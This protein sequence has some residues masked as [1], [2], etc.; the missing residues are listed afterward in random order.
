M[1]IDLNALKQELLDD[2]LNLGYDQ[3]VS[4]RN[5]LGSHALIN[6]VGEGSDFQ[7]SRGRISKDHFIEITTSMVFNL[8][9]ALKNGNQDAQF[10]LDVFD[11]LVANSDTINVD[12]PALNSILNEMIT[13]G[14]LTSQDLDSIKTR[15]GS[16][17]EKLF[18]IA[19]TVDQVSNSLNEVEN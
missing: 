11:R 16:R 6:S 18:G 17:S 10:W 3:F 9:V 15:Q 1:A 2:P 12:D 14:L 7:V 5:D 4:V 8:M 13:D 19:V